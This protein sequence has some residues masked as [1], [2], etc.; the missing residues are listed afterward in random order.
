MRWLAPIIGA[1]C[2]GCAGAMIHLVFEHWLV[3]VA[4][5]LSIYAGLLWLKVS[6]QEVLKK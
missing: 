3:G 1:I 6:I 2:F 5:T 4:I